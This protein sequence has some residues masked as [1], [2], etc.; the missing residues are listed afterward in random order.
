MKVCK[1]YSAK[2]WIA[3]DESLA[4]KIVQKWCDEIGDCW[5]VTPTSYVYTDGCESGVC[6]SRIN[7]PKFSAEPKEIADRA[8]N[9]ALLLKDGMAQQSYSIE[10]SDF[11]E[12]SGY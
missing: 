11:T 7:Y 3:G 9:L 4:I 10:F 6:V 8:R 2:I 1:T 5:T 12:W